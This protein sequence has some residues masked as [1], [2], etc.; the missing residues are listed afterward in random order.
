[1]RE[2]GTPL[3]VTPD[4]ETELNVPRVPYPYEHAFDAEGTH[5][6]FGYGQSRVVGV[7]AVTGT[8]V[9]DLDNLPGTPGGQGLVGLDGEDLRG[10]AYPV[11]LSVSGNW[12]VAASLERIH[13]IPFGAA[14]DRPVEWY[15]CQFGTC[16]AVL[17]EGRIVLVG[18]RS[19]GVVFG[20]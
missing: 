8:P 7:E 16:V 13:L 14:A 11:R 15:T 18:A 6:F 9:V 19:G 1:L 2:R 17:R 5:Y 12:L 10:Q 3:A 20:L 4:G